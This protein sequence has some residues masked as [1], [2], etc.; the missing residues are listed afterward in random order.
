MVGH[1]PALRRQI[2]S[3]NKT[4]LTAQSQTTPPFS[5]RLLGT[6]LVAWL[7]PGGGFLLHG[8]FWRGITVLGSLLLTFLLGCVLH[9]GVYWPVW[10]IHN[11]GFNII[12]NITFV[13]Q[14][15]SGLPALLSLL[16]S[17]HPQIFFLRWAA[18]DTSHALYDLG[19]F[20]LLACGAMN[21]FVVCNT[22]DR[23]FA[24]RASREASQEVAR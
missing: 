22:F 16:A 24:R 1:G 9:A 15:G 3:R 7:I 18:A 10:S 4:S 5:A 8:R 13:I 2:Y 20:Y 23:L 12:N 14:M 17:A 19:S 21:Y 11:E 6:V